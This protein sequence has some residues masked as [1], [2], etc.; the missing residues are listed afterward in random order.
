MA[1]S[2]ARHKH[3]VVVRSSILGGLPQKAGLSITL[4]LKKTCA[5]KTCSRRAVCGMLA[6][7]GCRC[8]TNCSVSS[9]CNLNETTGATAEPESSRSRSKDSLRCCTY[10][11]NVVALTLRKKCQV[12]VPNMA[13]ASRRVERYR[14]RK[15]IAFNC[16]RVSDTDAS[17]SYLAVVI[18]SVRD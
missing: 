6:S 13:S 17:L 18:N 3:S 2:R 12:R 7:P 5:T 9:Q 4:V 16:A 15:T 11:N 14:L 10:R 8:A 1:A